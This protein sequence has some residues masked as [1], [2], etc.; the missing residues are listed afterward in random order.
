MEN[1]RALLAVSPDAPLP[2]QSDA[3]SADAII[4]VH[5]Q[6]EGAYV[7]AAE[8]VSEAIDLGAPVYLAIPT[9][10]SGRCR[11]YLRHALQ[12]GVYGV[13]VQTAASIDQLRYLES[14]LED[15]EQRARIRPGLTAIAAGFHDPRAL[16]IMADALS[17]MRS[18][19]DRIAW[20]AY[21]HTEMAESLGVPTDSPTVA[22]ARA[23]AVITAAAF[24]L[25]IVYGSP[26]E[27]EYA[28]SLGFRGCATGEP[29]EL[30]RLH[31]IFTQP[32]S[33]SDA[34]EKG[35]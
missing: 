31:A 24:D 15:L 12:P 3:V 10:D 5:P 20:I 19:A 13:A 9:I 25:P 27:A 18:S 14:L 22:V 35:S 8:R 28:A 1:V 21:D 11:A 6:D 16:N 26:S 34:V 29:A 17:A 7:A 23:Q 30:A 33:E 32:E 2:D 4:L